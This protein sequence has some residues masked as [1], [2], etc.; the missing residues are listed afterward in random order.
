MYFSSLII[1]ASIAA[2]NRSS[3]AEDLMVEFTRAFCLAEQDRLA[4]AE[5][6]VPADWI[7][8]DRREERNRTYGT[9]APL[10]RHD[11]FE[12]AWR[13]RVGGASMWLRVW[14][15]DYADPNSFDP[16]SVTFGVSPDTAIDLHSFQQRLGIVMTPWRAPYAGRAQPRIVLGDYVYPAQPQRYGQLQH[17]V[18]S[19]ARPNPNIRITAR[20]FFGTGYP[21]QLFDLSC[22]PTPD[23]FRSDG[24]A[25]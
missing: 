3:P 10:R 24:A 22:S 25:R 14:R 5:R 13:G 4:A 20:H 18:L 1:A 11:R 8:F 12:A 23:A 6:L 9:D 2:A 7:G 21:Q 15:T 19:P 17:Y 16:S